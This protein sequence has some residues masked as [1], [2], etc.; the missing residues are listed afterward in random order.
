MTTLNLPEYLNIVNR[1]RVDVSRILPQLDPTIENSFINAIIT[2]NSGRHYDNVLSIR[3]L[4][5]ELFPQT[6]GAESLA[7]W[8]RYEG[9]TRFA[10]NE[11]R[12]SVVFTGTNLA[13]I[14]SGTRIRTDDNKVYTTDVATQ[15]TNATIN[16][17]SVTRLGNT[18]TVRTS[19]AHNLASNISV[20]IAG[21]DQT[22]YNGTFTI[23]VLSETVFTYE[24]TATPSSPATGTV[25]ISC[26]C[27]LVAVT[28]VE[29]GLAQNLAS[30]SRLS[31]T[32]SISG[33]NVAAHV[34]ALGITGGQDLESLADWLIRIEQRRENPV[35]NFN[36]SA[37]E[38]RVRLIQ[39]VTR[40]RVKRN[41]PNVGFV[42]ILFVRDDDENII[43]DSGQVT[44][45]RNSILEILPATN[46][47]SDVVVLAPTAVQTDYNFASITPD[48]LTMRNAII[49]NIRAYYRD[50]VNFETTITNDQY[51]SAITE[52]IDPDTGQ[53]LTAFTLSSPTGDIVVGDNQLAISGNIIFA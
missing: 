28:S 21:A 36:A 39:G 34:S 23:T 22:D 15:I 43:P 19:A 44:L 14:A 1:S 11:A 3:Q 40:V 29:V 7:R 52:T 18:V 45:V 10:P 38:A 5:K 16:A 6:A 13:Q 20:T 4:I 47:E 49:N 30:G 26:T 25:T 33:V 27:V 24:I 8:S 35:A 48:T 2:S 37:I 51:R 53:T 50:V 32:T 42:T 17:S 12:G 41:N 46:E 31:L 9:L